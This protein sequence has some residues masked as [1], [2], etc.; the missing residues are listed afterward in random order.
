[1]NHQPLLNGLVYLIRIT[2][3]R[4]SSVIGFLED[5]ESGEI[6]F[7]SEFPSYTDAYWALMEMDSND[8]LSKVEIANLDGKE[9]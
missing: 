7:E 3:Q 9:F 2:G 6:Y 1:M 4:G 5:K 8:Y